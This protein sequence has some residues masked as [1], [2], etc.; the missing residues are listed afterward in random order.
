MATRLDLIRA[1]A[2]E[3]IEHG[4]VCV[5]ANAQLPSTPSRETRILLDYQDTRTIS[6]FHK[7]ELGSILA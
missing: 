6:A 5:W 7:L 1:A 4:Y 2:S 3:L